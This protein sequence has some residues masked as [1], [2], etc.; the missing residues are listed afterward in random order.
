[1]GSPR[2]ILSD[3]NE[4]VEFKGT[5]NL[6]SKLLGVSKEGLRFYEQK[7]LISP[8]RD[9]HTGYRVY[10]GEEATSVE[11][12]KKY[13]KYGFSLN[14]VHDLI[15][16]PSAHKILQQFYSQCDV[17]LRE[18]EEK[19]RILSSLHGKIQQLENVLSCQGEFT[20]AKRPAFY[21]TPVILN[22]PH[23][24][25]RARL[26]SGFS[27]YTDSVITWPLG[28]LRGEKG[29]ARAGCMIEAKDIGTLPIKD[30]Y[31]LPEAK[32]LYT[33]NDVQGYCNM[34]NTIFDD[35]LNYMQKNKL[36]PTGDA[37]ARI[38]CVFVDEANTHHF[39][40]QLWI[41]IE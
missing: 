11:A 27:P 32:C 17:L 30:G 39:L 23:C 21:W 2:S 33:V 35:M 3:E 15:H 28:K 41:P 1:M 22:E 16:Q 37:V 7:G 13:R 34:F 25:A 12:C 4:G 40:S 5:V 18:I 20:V 9:A 31:F 19:K 29:I 6:Y 36:T 10:G 26:W 38:V 8:D 14:K 24:I